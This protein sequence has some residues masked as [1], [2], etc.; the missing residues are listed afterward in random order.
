[1]AVDVVTYVVIRITSVTITDTDIN[2]LQLVPFR[3]YIL[4]LD[5]EKSLTIT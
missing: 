3:R 5:L 2:S 4:V 1:M